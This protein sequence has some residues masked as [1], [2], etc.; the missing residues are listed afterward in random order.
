MKSNDDKIISSLL[1]SLRLRWDRDR[2]VA[3]ILPPDP[4]A[5]IG[6]RKRRRAGE[7]WREILGL[8]GVS[9]VL[10]AYSPFQRLVW[11]RVRAIPF[12]RTRSYGWVARKI[13]RPAAV[14]AVGRALKSNPWPLLIPCHRVIRADGSMGGFSSGVGWKKILLEWEQREVGE[15]GS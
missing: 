8:S 10:D 3:L 14:R 2:L 13:G 5:K 11:R 9:L 1:G 6:A 4:P 12:G 7:D 15:S